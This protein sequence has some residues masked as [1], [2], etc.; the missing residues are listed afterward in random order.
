[1][2]ELLLFSKGLPLVLDFGWLIAPLFADDL[3]DLWISKTRMLSN[4]LGLVVLTI[5]NKR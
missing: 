4:D 1:M 2:A 3:G 5:Q